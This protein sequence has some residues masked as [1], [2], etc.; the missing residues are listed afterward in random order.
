MKRTYLLAFGSLLLAASAVPAAPSLVRAAG[1]FTSSPVDAS[2]F[3][4]LARPVGD[5]DWNLLVLEQLAPAPRSS[6]PQPEGLVDPSLNRFDFTGIC[7]RYL[8]SNGYSL[9]IGEQDLATSYRL[10]LQQRGNLLLLQALSPNEATVL[11]VG[12][13]EVPRRDRDGFVAIQLEP[14]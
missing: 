6:T 3:S 9:R 11:V 1:M 7:S 12:R 10:R 14:G 4:V 8:D 5:S 2:R 13:A